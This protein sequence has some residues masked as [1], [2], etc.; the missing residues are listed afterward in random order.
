M[1]TFLLNAYLIDVL[2]PVLKWVSLGVVAL[3]LAIGLIACLVKKAQVAPTV[4]KLLIALFIY[5]LV[6]GVAFLAFEIG[7][8]YSEAEMAENYL[9]KAMVITHLL[10]PVV[11]T[12]IA[13]VVTAIVI[14]KYKAKKKLTLSLIL[15]DAV[16]LAVTV[17]L[18]AIYYNAKIA[19][20]GYYNSDT[21]SVN[22]V[23]LYVSSAVLI[24]FI[25]I[26]AFLFNTDDRP[27]DS[28][29]LAL[30]GITVAM[31]FGLSYVKLWEMP[32][33]GSI[34]LAS[35]LPIMLF[36]YIYGS[37]KGVLVCFAY[38]VLQAVQDPFII[39]PAQF[40]LDYPVAFAGVGLTGVLSTKIKSTALSF[41]LGGVCALV[42]R[43]VCHLLSGI[44]AFSAYAGETNAVI[45]SLAYNSFV[46]IDGAIVLAVGV[47][48][49]LSKA[50]T[51]E[52]KKI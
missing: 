50:F 12:L 16:F 2:E 17:I 10:L 32:Q 43:F 19:N 34:T 22:Q 40:L 5:T 3:L 6:V 18:M 21:A 26:F 33:G 23:V 25:V 48:L 1:Q 7:K 28:K 8:R 24:T 20:D 51:K 15:V 44:F 41:S 11:A 27:F 35:L 14:A 37:K 45:Y 29:C 49:L 39:H 46:F 4:K 30:A 13:I 31:S 52:L 9:D 47:M 38:G 36:S 42:F